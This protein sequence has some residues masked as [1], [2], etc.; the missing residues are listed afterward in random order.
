MRNATCVGY[1][2]RHPGG[3]IMG[4]SFRHRGGRA[5][6]VLSRV[7]CWRSK[8]VVAVALLAA[9][10]F[11]QTQSQEG[12]AKNPA[13]NQTMQTNQKKF[14]LVIHGGAGTMERSKITPEAEREYRAGL[15]RALNAGYEILK[16]GGTSFDATEAAVRVLEDDPHF[17]A[18][19]GAV[20]TSAGTNELDAAIMDGNTLKAG[21]V[22]SLKH[23]KNP[24]SLARLV[25]EKSGHVMMDG[26]G[27][28]AFAKEN[29]VQLVDQK[30]FFTQERWDALQKIKAAE[31]SRGGAGEKK[32]IIT[33]QD[34]HGTVGAVALDQQGNLA[35]ATS[36]GGTTN[37][38]AGRIGDSPIIGGGTYANNATC[39]VSATGD[40]EY[41]IRA[42]VAHDISALM[43]YRGMKLQ[44]A[45]QSVLDKVAKLGGTGGVIA[46]DRDGNI[47]L[48]FN[49]SGM[50]R[51]HV[52][53]DGKFVI[54]IYR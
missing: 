37:K 2:D 36:T 32:F 39:A 16:R 5:S 35:A 22:A 31:K 17:N 11:N 33:D 23:I 43:E 45:A 42:T 51:G 38:R 8:S 12:S 1:Q 15:E 20:F 9:T 6:K 46:I 48:P 21:T 47:A 7:V 10:A 52:D 3:V 28:E 30:Y 29:G 34:R 19:K 49:T 13:T 27:A 54:E 4:E 40:G 18:G 44:A 25:M 41:F 14:G 53:P 26:E 24:V 50:Y